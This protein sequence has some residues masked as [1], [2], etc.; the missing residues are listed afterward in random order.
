MTDIRTPLLSTNVNFVIF[1]K[2]DYN[3]LNGHLNKSASLKLCKW[4]LKDRS[5]F[6]ELVR[7]VLKNE[8]PRSGVASWALSEAARQKPEWILKHTGKL[9]QLLKEKNPHH[10]LCRNVF[11]IYEAVLV[12]EKHQ[13]LAF[14]LAINV[15]ADPKRSIA[16][17]AFAMIMGQ[18]ITE[19]HP[20]LKR[21]LE[22]VVEPLLENGSAGLKVRARR[23][24]K[25]K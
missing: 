9:L 21:E 17:R 12:T 16:E 6:D 25:V 15:V 22:M 8:H 5:H 10:T 7:E 24:L 1:E 11:R 3:L 20:D 2:M 13:S 4:A 18:K 19:V 14:D 23:I